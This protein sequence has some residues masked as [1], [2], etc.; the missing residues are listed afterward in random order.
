MRHS[1]QAAKRCRQ[2]EFYEIFIAVNG[3][4]TTPTAS[5]IDAKAVAS[6]QD[7]GAGNFR[8]VLKDKS[9]QEVVVGGIVLATAGRVG[10]VTAKDQESV[11]LQFTN[12]SGVAADADFN[13]CIGWLGTKHLF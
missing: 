3:T 9:P 11:T 1:M 13:I 5:G 8:I 12:L 10:R 6:V 2:I 4:A 7:L